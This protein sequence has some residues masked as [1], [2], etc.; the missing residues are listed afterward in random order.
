MTRFFS[1][2]VLGLASLGFFPAKSKADT[3]FSF[4]LNFG[5]SGFSVNRGYPYYGYSG[6]SNYYYSPRVIYDDGYQHYGHGHYGH[7]H[8]GGR[9]P[10]VVH[11]DYY[12]WT[13]D[14]GYHS[15]GHIH[16]PHRGHYHVRPY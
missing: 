10:V 16:V 5:N 6:Y 14:R 13:P 1:V 7:G 9:R 11:P 15:H 12:H 3:P 2:A 4:S 8:H